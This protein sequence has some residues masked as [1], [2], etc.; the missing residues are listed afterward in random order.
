VPGTIGTCPSEVQ[1]EIADAAV[2]DSPPWYSEDDSCTTT[3]HVPLIDVG[4]VKT[5]STAGPVDDDPGAS[6]QFSYTLTVTNHSDEGVKDATVTD[7]LPSQLVLD[8]S[9]GTDGLDLPSGWTASV[10]GQKITVT[11]PS[12]ALDEHEDITV[13]VLVKPVVQ[14]VPVVQPGDPAPTSTIPADTID[15]T[16]C[17]AIADDTDATNDCSTVKVPQKAVFANLWVQCQGD[18]P[19]LGY[20]IRTTANIASEPVTLTWTA[21]QPGTGGVPSTD[22]SPDP[23]QVVKTLHSGDSGKLLWPG[24]S[25][26]QNVGV[27]FPG[28]R[29]IVESDYNADGTLKFP[30]SQTFAGLVYDPSTVATD[31]W[32]YDSTV[33]IKVNPTQT[34]TVT[35]PAATPK[36]AVARTP[37]VSITKTA[38][39]AQTS[40]GASFSYDLAVKNTGLGAASPMTMSDPIP[41]D[42]KVTKITTSTS[43]FPRWQDCK[44][45]G[46]DAAGYGGTLH[47]DL[48]GPL[49]LNESAPKITVDVTVNKGTTVNTLTNTA[50]VKWTDMDNPKNTGSSKSS[51]SVKVLLPAPAGTLPV[52]GGTPSF[53]LIGLGFFVILAGATA[54]VISRRR[55]DGERD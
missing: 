47:C 11:I 24:G 17:V 7:T 29:P 21:S 49:K 45:T 44:V 31:A 32:R 40:P 34:A 37:D 25:V 27:G 19:Y 39:V 2:N 28:W 43:A 10:S 48:F 13:Y 22:L 51:V 53:G 3:N 20:D 42:L 54:L 4:I 41:A 50:T 30:A 14:T 35:Y 46:Q 12:L 23:S 8:T 38:S 5:A 36:C 55:R 1:P 18:I 26:Y 52:T 15:N 6:S 33:T 16:A 9:K